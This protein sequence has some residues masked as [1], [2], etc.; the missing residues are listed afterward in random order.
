V[1]AVSEH[2]EHMRIFGFVLLF[3]SLVFAQNPSISETDTPTVLTFVAPAY[4]RAAKEQ[5]MQGRAI[6][7]ITIGTDGKVVDVKTLS[8][9]PVFASYALPALK[10]WKFKPA[11]KE[12]TVEVTFSFEFVDVNAGSEGETYISA[13]LPKVVHIATGFPPIETTVSQSKR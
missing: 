11:Q 7:A 9:H 3:A 6:S 2:K 1:F 10:Q 8:A 4:P 5:R 13:E 12:Q